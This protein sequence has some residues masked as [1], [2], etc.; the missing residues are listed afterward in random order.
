M[1]MSPRTT[2]SGKPIMHIPMPPRDIVV[3]DEFLTPPIWVAMNPPPLFDRGTD[4][5]R[6]MSDTS[7]S[8]GGDEDEDESSA[9][10]EPVTAQEPDNNTLAVPISV[11]LCIAIRLIIAGS[12][13]SA[14]T[15][16]T[17]ADFL[18]C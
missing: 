18:E 6:T 7:T 10:S 9:N 5:K 2:R 16:T 1:E 14:I 11:Y 4:M 15:R 8:W 12:A 17:V 13:S 3:Q